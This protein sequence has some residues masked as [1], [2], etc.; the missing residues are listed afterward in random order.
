MP[1]QDINCTICKENFLKRGRSQEG[2]VC[3]WCVM[4]KTIVISHLG[5]IMHRAGH[6][7]YEKPEGLEC[8]AAILYKLEQEI[9]EKGLFGIK[10]TTC[11]SHNWKSYTGVVESYQY[12]ELCYEKL[13]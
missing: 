5:N 2:F 13:K 9:N 12:C 11:I 7:P 8:Y 6:V 3:G 10:A 4:D 1:D